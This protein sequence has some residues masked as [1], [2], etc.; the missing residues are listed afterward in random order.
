MTVIPIG[1]GWVC[2]DWG[3]I[4]FGWLNQTLGPALTVGGLTLVGWSVRVQYILGKGTPAPKV[5]TQKLVTQGPYAFSRNPMTLGALFLYLGIRVWMGSGVV[6]LLT[7]IVF[8]ALLTFIY[9]HE[10]RELTD[11]FGEEYL[12]Y[13]MRT[14]F[15]CPRFAML[16][17][18]ASLSALLLVYVALGITMMTI[19]LFWKI[20]LHA[21]GVGGFAAFLTWMFGPVWALT[22]LAIPLVGWARVY[23]QRHNWAQVV[24]GGIVG[25]SVTLIILALVQ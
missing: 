21:G 12:A 16:N 11:R 5:A 22:F 1:I 9:L 24:A 19:S 3:R 8:S 2:G 10:T 15:L 13:K 18:P 17:A 20:S 7:V 25:V 23:R 4:S 6:M 14:P